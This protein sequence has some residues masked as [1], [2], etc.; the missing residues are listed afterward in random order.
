MTPVA[1]KRATLAD[2]ARTDG[3]AEPIG[4]RIVPLMGQVTGEPAAPGW[5]VLL[6][7]LFG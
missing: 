6:D 2:L 4:G 5:R 7:Q 1:Q 3:K